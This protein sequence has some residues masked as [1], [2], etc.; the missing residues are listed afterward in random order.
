MNTDSCF[1]LGYLAKIHGLKGEIKAIFEADDPSTYLKLESVFVQR[2]Q[3]LIPFFIENI[4][5][6]SSSLLLKFEG[7]DTP[8]EASEL[9][10]SKLYLPL[11]LLPQLGEDEFYFH[12]II[13]FEAIDSQYG[14]IGRIQDYYS[15]GPQDILQ[16]MDND[17]EI[18]IP[19]SRD[20]IQSVNKEEKVI[21]FELP[22]GLIDVYLNP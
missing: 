4:R 16:V 13:G 6:G 19:M 20:F 11:D 14:S 1:Q 18:L 9:S 7:I 8:E 21:K 15:M 10:G 17:K 22:D 2:G 12:E 3:T 5:Q